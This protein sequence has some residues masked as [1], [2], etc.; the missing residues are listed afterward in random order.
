METFAKAREFVDNPR[1]EIERNR[2]TRTLSLESIDSP[3]RTIV[4]SFAELTYCFT[5]QSCFGHFVH[6]D[7]PEPD[8]L[9]PLPEHDVGNVTYRIAYFALCLRDSAQGRL[10]LSNLAEFPSIDP[11]YVQFGSPGWFWKRHLNSFAIQV[12]PARFANKDQAMIGYREALRVQKI[13]D[14]FFA[15]LGMLARSMQNENSI[16]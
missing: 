14:E 13:R 11:E 3:I 1:Y 2:V 6:A 12:E 10:L 9:E 15:R 5:L 7:Q 16:A 4:A 8:N